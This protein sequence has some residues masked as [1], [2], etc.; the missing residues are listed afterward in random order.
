MKLLVKFIG[1]IGFLG[2]FLAFGAGEYYRCP[3]QPLKFEWL[4]LAERHCEAPV[5][6]YT[7]LREKPEIYDMDPYDRSLI[8]HPTLESVELCGQVYPLEY[9]KMKR[10]NKGRSPDLNPNETVKVKPAAPIVPTSE[11][12]TKESKKVEEVLL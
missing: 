6:C 12:P 11:T 4:K 8:G 7:A 1:F 2:S 10:L 5:I 9:Q 3:G